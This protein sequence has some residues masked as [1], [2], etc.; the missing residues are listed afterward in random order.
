MQLQHTNQLSHIDTIA[1]DADDTLW[2]SEDGFHRVG[3]Q[4]VELLTPF[5]PAET[6]IL[7]QL[8]QREKA[9]VA[10]FGYGVKSST[11]SM[12]ET[13]NTLTRGGI[14]ADDLASVT[15]QIVELGRWLLTRDTVVFT[16]AAHV[17]AQ[18]SETYRLVLITKGDQ[19]HQLSKVDESGLAVHFDHI[20]VVSEKD[21]DTYQGLATRHNYDLVNFVMIGNS[22]KSDIL[23]VLDAGGTAIHIPYQFTWDLEQAEIPDAHPGRNRFIEAT[24]LRDVLTLLPATSSKL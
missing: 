19:H 12:I 22:V 9:N 4:F 24:S 2:H 17:L 13:A 11:F 14:G 15:D 6:N 10:V 7:K 8:A 18:L 21:I 5:V 20:E 1:F 16:D 3:E 23:P